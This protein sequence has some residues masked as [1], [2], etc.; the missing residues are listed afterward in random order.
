ML[1]ALPTAFFV[2]AAL[3]FLDA[4]PVQAQ[5]NINIGTPPPQYVVVRE[6]GPAK[7]WKG[8]KHK[9]GTVLLV[10][11]G[12]VYYESRGHGRGRGRH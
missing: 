10:P 3:A 5:I 7:K 2:L 6:V 12:P 4:T 1:K 9:K 8:P 11:A